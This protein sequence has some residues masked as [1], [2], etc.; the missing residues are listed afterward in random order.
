[1][2]YEPHFMRELHEIR[3][4]HYEETKHLSAEERCRTVNRRAREYLRKHGH[5][6]VPTGH[7]I[8]RIV[9]ASKHP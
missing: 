9:K 8:Y 7:G 3:V 4:R 5:V 1:M 6:L 2:S